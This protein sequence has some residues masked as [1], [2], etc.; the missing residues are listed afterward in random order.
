M[1]A[2]IIPIITALVGAAGVGTS[3]YSLVNQPGAP[4]TTTPTLTPEQATAQA[5]QTRQNQQ[6][7]LSQAL[8]GEQA[9]VGGAL[10]PESLLRLAEQISGQGGA[11]GIESS[12]QDLISKM[13]AQSS[14][15]NVTAGG[16]G[17][18]TSG[19]LSTTSYG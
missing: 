18:G 5:T 8:P 4:K 9:R 3:I 7:A 12:I 11:P 17:A 2:A 15:V 1:P 13:V 10:S 6:A 19:G 16:G 14:G